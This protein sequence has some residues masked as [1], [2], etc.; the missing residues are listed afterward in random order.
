M[1]LR[2]VA[3]TPQ[4]ATSRS[5]PYLLAL[6]TPM[7]STR[8]GGGELS[9]VQGVRIACAGEQ[10]AHIPEL[11]DY[12]VPLDHEVFTVGET[13]QVSELIGITI[14]F[15]KVR[16][17]LNYAA[18]RD[19]FGYALSS[20]HYPNPA[21]EQLMMY[22]NT[23]EANVLGGGLALLETPKRWSK[24]VGSVI[25]VRKDLKPLH[26]HHVEVLLKFIQASKE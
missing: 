11:T 22:C 17:C 19:S 9:S 6:S 18:T 13:S 12:D 2:T 24:G 16:P 10:A 20:S 8:E 15:S 26:A 5:R 25:A 4:L 3:I 23:T 21:V 1:P 7:A 14:L